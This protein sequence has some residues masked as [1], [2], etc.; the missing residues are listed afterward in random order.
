MKLMKKFRKKRNKLTFKEDEIFPLFNNKI[1]RKKEKK[2]NNYNN[3][4]ICYFLICIFFFIY[5]NYFFDII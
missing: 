4:S 3:K 2:N 5:C 1:F